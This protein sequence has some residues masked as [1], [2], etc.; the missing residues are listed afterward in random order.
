MPQSALRIA[1]GALKPEFEVSDE[2]ASCLPL[3]SSTFS[4]PEPG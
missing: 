2:K 4:M 1:D 3:M